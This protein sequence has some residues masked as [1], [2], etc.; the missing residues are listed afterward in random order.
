[1]HSIDL[2]AP[3]EKGPPSLALFVVVASS[4]LLISLSCRF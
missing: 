2:P 1:M 4:L 3:T